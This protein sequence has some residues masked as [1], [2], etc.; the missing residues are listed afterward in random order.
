MHVV[1]LMEFEDMGVGCSGYS[2]KQVV[3]ITTAYIN[4]NSH[5]VKTQYAITLHKP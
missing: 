2:L 5:N 3:A 4:T 1:W